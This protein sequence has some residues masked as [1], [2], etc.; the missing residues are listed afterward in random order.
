VAE[1]DS[2]A[3]ATGCM[4]VISGQVGRQPAHTAEIELDKIAHEL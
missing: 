2:M 4:G 3:E 1:Y